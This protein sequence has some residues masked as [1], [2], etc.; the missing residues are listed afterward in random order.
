[1][2]DGVTF[3]SDTLA[4]PAV[5]IEVATDDAGAAGHVQIVKLAVSA[6]GSAVPITGD[7]DGL[8]V[9]LGANNDVTVSSSTLPSGAASAANQTTIIGHVDGIEALLTTIDADTGAMA[10]SLAIVDNIVFGAGTEAAALRV[11]V[12]TD[13]TGVLSVDDNGSTLSIDDGAG[14]ITVDN[15]GTFAVQAAQSGAWTVGLPAGAS[16]SANQTTIIGHL[17]GVEGLLTTID[18]D[19]GTLAVTGGGVE[20]GALRVTIANNST[21]VLSVDDNGS[22]LTVDGSVSIAAA[23]PAGTNNIGDVDVLTVPA[24]LSTTGGGTE[25]AALRVT[26]ANDSTGLVSVDDNGSSLTVD[27]SGTFSV[28]VTSSQPGSTAS[29]LGKN[30]DAPH[31]TGDTGVAVWGVRNDTAATTFGTNGDYTPLATDSAGRIGVADLGGS[32]SVDDNAG[33]LTVDAPVAT[34]VFVR[35]SDGAAAISALPVTDNGGSL[36]VDGSVAATQSGTWTVQHAS[37]GMGDGRKTV[38]TAGTAEA[39]AS[40][41]PAKT[42]MI[43]AELDNTGLVVVGGS[44]VVATLASRRGTPLSAGDTV[45]MPIDNLADVFLDVTVS[46]DGVTYSFTT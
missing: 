8:L 6:D 3:Q 37:T 40:S 17:D 32:I 36:T 20:A 25:A 18:S 29:S 33:S 21:G 14:S 5:G 35:L 19:T 22:S 12:A 26:L 23:I 39:L 46:G 7:A 15:A 42:V 2:A 10:T 38:A 24:P 43:T 31:N 27:N 13:S 16:S 30:E 4:T 34:P 9:N 45:A 1:M 44:T 11:T 41:T 28:Q